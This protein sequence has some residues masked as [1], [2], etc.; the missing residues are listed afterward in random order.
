MTP[1]LELF[2]KFTV[3]VPSPVPKCWIVG[4]DGMVIIGNRSSRITFGAHE[5]I[6]TQ[7][8]VLDTN[9]LKSA[10]LDFCNGSNMTKIETLQ[11]LAHG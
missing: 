2:R 1:P 7:H 3:L 6:F 10:F 11:K 4:W 9:R 5:V 8:L